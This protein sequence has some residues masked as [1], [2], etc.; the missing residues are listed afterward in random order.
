MRPLL[1]NSTIWLAAVL[2][3]P[4][5]HAASAMDLL[6]SAQ[7]TVSG[8][9]GGMLASQLGVSEDQATG[10]IGSMLT[11]AQE[12][13]QAG[14]FDRLAGYIPG[15]DGYLAAAKQ[16]GAVVGPIGNLSGLNSALS[17]LGMDADTVSKFVPT[18]TDLVG[19]TGGDD[20]RQLLTSALG[21]S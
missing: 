7:D 21:G 17:R 16:L 11:L 1:I 6:K 3:T 10:G 9:L 20:A 8:S 13:L 4:A 15:A 12:K 2:L 5:V 18:V 14:D 19:K